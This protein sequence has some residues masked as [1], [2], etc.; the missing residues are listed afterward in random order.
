MSLNDI[1][2]TDTAN[3]YRNTVGQDYSELAD[4]V[5]GWQTLPT[6]VAAGLKSQYE[7]MYSKMSSN[8]VGQLEI[9]MTMLGYNGRQN[10]LGI[11]VAL[12]HPWSRGSIFVTST[13]PFTAPAIDPDYFGAPYDIDIMRYGSLFARRVAGQAP[14]SNVMTTESRPGADI[15]G[16]ALNNFTKQSAGTEYHPL[17]TCSMLPRNQG[18]VVD[19]NLVVYGTANLRVV[20]ASIMPLQISA[21]LMASTY[22]I[23][24][25]GADIIKQKYWKVEETNTTST[26][27]SAAAETTASAGQATDSAVTEQNNKAAAGENNLSTGAKIGI[28]A[29]VGVG[30]AALL[31]GLVSFTY[32]SYMHTL[33]PACILPGPEGETPGTRNKGLVRPDPDQRPLGRVQ[34]SRE[35]D[36]P[37]GPLRGAG[38]PPVRVH[39]HHGHCGAGGPSAHEERERLRQ[40]LWER[41]RHA[42]PGWRGHPAQRTGRRRRV[43]RSGRFG[44]IP[45]SAD[46]STGEYVVDGPW[47]EYSSRR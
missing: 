28:G 43:Q 3:D 37:H 11:Q 45:P 12:Q 35:R 1:M 20:D 4:T 17:G 29:G 27:G 26:S 14:L 22:G 25:K 41:R 47:S 9:I 42:V 10:E 32:L 8:D 18:G 34:G 5:A 23:A 7:I 16:D 24:E 39:G 30:A 44:G 36:V 33:T 38:T 6:N 46:L 31:A 21:H 19:T 2:D 40:Q 15:T 13:D